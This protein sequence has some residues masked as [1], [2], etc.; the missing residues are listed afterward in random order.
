MQTNSE[1]GR[2]IDKALEVS[3]R[4]ANIP[5]REQSRADIEFLVQCNRLR[6]RTGRLLKAIGPRHAACTFANYQTVHDGQREVVAELLK[7]AQSGEFRNVILYGTK[8]TGKDHLLMALAKEFYT[9]WGQVPMWVN[10]VD[11]FD[12]LRQE[13]LGNS[14]RLLMYGDE[15]YHTAQMLWIS[16]PLP[17]TGVLSE[18]QQSAL[19]RIIDI[20][21]RNFLPTWISLN[22][23]GGAEAEQRLGAQVVDRLRHGALS[24]QCYWPSYRATPVSKMPAMAG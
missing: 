22:V 1:F 17:P 9:L 16:D 6:A 10:G 8:G 5:K 21:Y 23:Q 14:P 13:A 20:R 4:C 2:F 24:L 7:H 18:F 15:D 11:L 3:A 19:F 12:T